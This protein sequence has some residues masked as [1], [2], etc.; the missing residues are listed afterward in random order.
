MEVEE[1]YGM[2]EKNSGISLKLPP[3]GAK[4]FYRGIFKGLL[5]IFPRL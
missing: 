2:A 5:E 4:C 3:E 1:L